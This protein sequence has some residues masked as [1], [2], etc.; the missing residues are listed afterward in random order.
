[1]RWLRR[2]PAPP[3]ASYD[4][5]GSLIVLVRAADAA[6]ADSA[7]LAEAT[8]AGIDLSRPLLVRHHLVLPDRVAV[9]RAGEL[10]GQDG[11]RLTVLEPGPPW[12][13]RA[14]RTQVPTAMSASQERS[15]MA[16]LA[17]RPGGDVR[18]WDACGPG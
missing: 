12:V 16:G 13:V 18:G 1:M 4:D 15:R 9:D 7:V 11:Y 17:Q 5:D 8:A 6:R 14:W 2:R 10:L 3:E